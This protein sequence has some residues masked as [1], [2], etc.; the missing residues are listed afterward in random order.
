[1]IVFIGSFDVS[2]RV[3]LHNIHCNHDVNEH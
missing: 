2:S 1:L 3:E